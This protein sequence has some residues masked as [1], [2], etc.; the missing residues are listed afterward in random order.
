MEKNKKEKIEFDMYDF[1]LES[2][3]KYASMYEIIGQYF[4]ELNGNYSTVSFINKFLEVAENNASR[5]F[6]EKKYNVSFDE[7][8]Q[9]LLVANQGSQKPEG[10]C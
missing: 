3:T 6:V 4:P 1:I 7:L 9:I 5:N 8:S 10:R 2:E